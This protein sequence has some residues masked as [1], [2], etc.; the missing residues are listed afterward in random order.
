MKGLMHPIKEVRQ[1]DENGTQVENLIDCTEKG[2]V[3][4]AEKACHCQCSCNAEY[5]FHI[6]LKEPLSAPF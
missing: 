3:I 5:P 4:P 2:E 6:N 1:M